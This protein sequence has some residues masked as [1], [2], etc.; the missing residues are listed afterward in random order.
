LEEN[1]PVD[2]LDGKKENLKKRLKMKQEQRILSKDK[3]EG[4]KRCLDQRMELILKQ[5]EKSK[6][7]WMTIQERQDTKMVSINLRFV[8]LKVFAKKTRRVSQF[9]IFIVFF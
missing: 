3:E 6:A 4:W 8:R 5:K 9:L 7:F 1:L 2:T